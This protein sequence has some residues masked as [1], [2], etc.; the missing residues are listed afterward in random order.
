MTN[1]T[2]KTNLSLLNFTRRNGVK[3]DSSILA[4]EFDREVIEE[5]LQKVFLRIKALRQ[6][7]KNCRNL[8]KLEIE[9]YFQ[10]FF[11]QMKRKCK[12]V[13]FFLHPC[14]KSIFHLMGTNVRVEVSTA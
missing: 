14:F 9:T 13:F 4:T 12:V 3:I 11:L 8:H 1:K 6:L 7:G 10:A 2:G 5:N